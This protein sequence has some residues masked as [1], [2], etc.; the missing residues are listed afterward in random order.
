MNDHI[1]HFVGNR[2]P[3]LF[4]TILIDGTPVNLTG[5]TVKLQMR[6]VGESTFTVDAAAVVVTAVDGEVRYD[7]AALDV[8]TAGM[9]VIWWRVTDG[10]GKTQDTPESLFEIREHNQTGDEYISVGELK[11]SLEPFRH[12]VCRRRSDGRRPGSLERHRRQVRLTRGSACS[13]SAPQAK[14]GL[15]TACQRRIRDVDPV[16]TITA[17]EGSGDTP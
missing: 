12:D 5:S 6:E 4:G 10:T 7:W 13:R 1:V 11:E 16:T 15:Y 3:S 14:N 9:Y 17:V 8:D 2:S